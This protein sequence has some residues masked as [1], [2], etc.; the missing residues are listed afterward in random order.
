M[1]DTIYDWKQGAGRDRNVTSWPGYR[2]GLV[3]VSPWRLTVGNETTNFGF[4]ATVG[5]IAPKNWFGKALSSVV[6]GATDS[7]IVKFG[8]DGEHVQQAQM[9]ID[10]D[11]ADLPFVTDQYVGSDATINAAIEAAD[12]TV[13]NI[14]L[15]EIEAP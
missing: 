15:I 13:L 1:A 10:T 5:A 6:A 2:P 12:G 4:N 11:T 9:K 14:E 7:L 8:D 3:S